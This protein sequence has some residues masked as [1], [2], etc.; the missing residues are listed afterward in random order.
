[1]KRRQLQILDVLNH[2]RYRSYICGIW[3]C[4]HYRCNPENPIASTLYHGRRGIRVCEEWYDF[5]TF[6]KWAKENN[7]RKGR[8]I[9]RIDNDGHY[10]PK[11]CQ[12]L[13]LSEHG[14]KTWR[15]YCKRFKK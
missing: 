14:R 10:C 3:S 12:V 7:Y 4:M 8:C 5:E 6:L 2:Q 11:N 1:M 9:D 15:D 13:T